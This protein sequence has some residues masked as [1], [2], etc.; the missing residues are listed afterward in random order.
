M[1]SDREKCSKFADQ[2]ILIFSITEAEKPGLMLSTQANQLSEQVTANIID[3]PL[4]E[5]LSTQ[6]IFLQAFLLCKIKIIRL[7][8]TLLYAHSSIGLMREHYN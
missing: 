4:P 3:V 6:E 1:I 5:Y 8:E 7:S 2:D